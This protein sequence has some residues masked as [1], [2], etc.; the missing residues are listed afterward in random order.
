MIEV[1]LDFLNRKI[2]S[3]TKILFFISFIEEH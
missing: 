1:I 3:S 2:I